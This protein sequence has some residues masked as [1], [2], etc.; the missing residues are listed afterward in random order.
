[1]KAYYLLLVAS[2]SLFFSCGQVDSNWNGKKSKGSSSDSRPQFEIEE[3]NRARSEEVLWSWS[4]ALKA[5]EP[6][7]LTLTA[8]DGKGGFFNLEKNARFS[9]HMKC[10]GSQGAFGQVS[11]SD[12]AIYVEDIVFFR[13]GT[14]VVEVSFYLA[15]KEIKLRQELKVTEPRA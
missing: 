3:T 11:V 6:I 12:D 5:K 14:W 7:K 1:M 4:P 9:V 8:K 10:C 2:F 13:K 15:D